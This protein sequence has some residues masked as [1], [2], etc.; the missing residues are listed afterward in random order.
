M[1]SAIISEDC[2]YNSVILDIWILLSKEAI[3]KWTLVS[4]AI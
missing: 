4:G 2:P 3:L 1:R